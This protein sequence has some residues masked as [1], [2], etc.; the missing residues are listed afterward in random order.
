LP[1]AGLPA[2]PWRGS[3]VVGAAFLRT[4]MGFW[5]APV[6][7]RNDCWPGIRRALARS[8]GRRKVGTVPKT[9]S[10]PVVRPA[11]PD[12]K[13]TPSLPFTPARGLQASGPPNRLGT[14]PRLA[15]AALLLPCTALSPVYRT[16]Q[17]FSTSPGA[18]M[19]DGTR[20]K[21]ARKTGNRRGKWGRSRRRWGRED[22]A[23][24]GRCRKRENASRI[25]IPRRPAAAFVFFIRLSPPLPE[26]FGTRS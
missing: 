25:R 14:R 3:P 20:A 5:S 22:T 23:R 12:A 21:E 7:P 10:H 16:P 15:T 1:L 13:R 26:G 4:V 18:L 2:G 24:E 11:Y 19:T 8:R 9:T 17:G 6:T